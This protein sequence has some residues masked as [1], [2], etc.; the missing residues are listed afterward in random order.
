[1]A[2][3]TTDKFA[4]DILDEMSVPIAK[5]QFL[6]DSL[7]GSFDFEPGKDGKAGLQTILQEISNGFYE[8]YNDLKKAAG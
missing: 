5:L 7:T 2:E 1:M 8:I 4:N 6:A 3:Q